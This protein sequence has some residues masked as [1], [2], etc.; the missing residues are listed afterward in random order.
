MCVCVWAGGGGGGGGKES[1]KMEFEINCCDLS[2]GVSLGL[3][4]FWSPERVI[5]AEPISG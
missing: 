4:Q 3:K 5:N 1:K 2:L